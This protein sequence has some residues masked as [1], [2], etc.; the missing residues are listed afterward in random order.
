MIS[1]LLIT[2]AMIF[3]LILCWFL[4]VG[5][6]VLHRSYALSSLFTLL[7][8]L[9]FIW[10]AWYLFHQ[11]F[12]IWKITS[13][14]PLVLFFYFALT[15]I[16][17]FV[18][19]QAGRFQNDRSFFR[20]LVNIQPHERAYEYTHTNESVKSHPKRR[21]EEKSIPTD[22]NVK[23][24]IT[25]I[26]ADHTRVIIIA[27][28]AFRNRHTAPYVVL[29]QWLAYTYDVISLDF[30]GHGESGGYYDFS[31]LTVKDLKAV[32]EYAQ[33]C[34]YKKIGVFSRSMG[35]W[36]A[37]MEAARYQNIDSLIASASP[38]GQITAISLAQKLKRL[39]QTPVAGPLITPLAQIFVSLMKG[40]RVS[41]VRDAEECPL[42][43]AD[44]L[45]DI[46]VY[47]IYHEEDP[48]I[49]TTP[50]EALQL[51]EAISGEKQLLI[52]TGRGHI[53]ELHQFYRLYQSI[54]AWFDR[55]LSEA[56]S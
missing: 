49:E 8:T 23:I 20:S 55:T 30:R 35:A 47:L 13:L 38:L 10:A 28:G 19:L 44:R 14:I 33:G 15:F 5:W 32:V 45:G 43:L 7:T 12:L 50:V 26:H 48:V 29:A 17:I 42:E 36:S 1:G 16:A 27:H 22:D 21:H 46:P 54:E 18:V 4:F 39:I 9:L 52:L 2:L 34:G 40:T 24:R 31:D 56:A 11:D 3:W 51:Y 25:H 37:L 6:H 41:G 53:F